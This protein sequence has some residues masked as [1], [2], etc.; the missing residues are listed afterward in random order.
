MI[1]PFSCNTPSL[2]ATGSKPPADKPEADP[3]LDAFQ[4]K[5]SVTF[6]Q[7][8]SMEDL[9]KA[10]RKNGDGTITFTFGPESGAHVVNHDQDK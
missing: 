5:T 4:V 1:K 9:A 3:F 7:P 10:M 6:D 2:A 8:I